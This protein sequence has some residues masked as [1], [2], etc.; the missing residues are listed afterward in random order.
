MV[1]NAGNVYVGQQYNIFKLVSLTT[2]TNVVGSSSSGYADGT[3]TAATFNY[4]TQVAWGAAS[5]D[6]LFISDQNG[7][8]SSTGQVRKVTISSRSTSSSTSVA[9]TRPCGLVVDSTYTN[10]YVTS[11]TLHSVYKIVISSLTASLYAGLGTSSKCVC[12]SV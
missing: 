10:M 9:I 6:V 12:L 2:G 3:G 1:D 7:G 11:S 5:Q 4:I 8:S